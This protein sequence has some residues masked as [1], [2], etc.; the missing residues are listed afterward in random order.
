MNF[1]AANTYKILLIFIVNIKPKIL[2]KCNFWF[3]IFN[4]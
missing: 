1:S 2:I 3:Y 4:Q